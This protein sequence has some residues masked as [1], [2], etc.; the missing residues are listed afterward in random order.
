MAE[1]RDVIILIT[2]E[3][4]TQKNKHK[5]GGRDLEATHVDRYDST[6]LCLPQW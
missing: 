6:H 4:P 2:Q 5:T 1:V 3:T